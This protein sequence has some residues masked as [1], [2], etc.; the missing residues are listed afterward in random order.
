MGIVVSIKVRDGS[1]SSH[2]DK[3][4]KEEKSSKGVYLPVKPK[5][6]I[7]LDHSEAVAGFKQMDQETSHTTSF[8]IRPLLS[9]NFVNLLACVMEIFC[10]FE[11]CQ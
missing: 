9:L 2:L 8:S 7:S 4:D 1:I 10:M 3:H 5:M 6:L 11:V